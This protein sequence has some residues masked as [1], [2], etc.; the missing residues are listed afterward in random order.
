MAAAS[1][2]T[3]D[4]KLEAC[5]ATVLEFLQSKCLFAAERALRTELELE[6]QRGTPHL[7]ARNLWTSKLENL[8]GCAHAR[9]HTIACTLARLR[10]HAR[11]GS[12]R[13][14]MSVG[15]TF[16]LSAVCM[17][18]TLRWR[19]DCAHGDSGRPSGLGQEAQPDHRILV[20]A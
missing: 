3:T 19:C 13:C 16:G 11:T 10:W 8:L 18:A 12:F 7:L 4:K 2:S 15:I 9:P 20:R 17:P 5:T 14:V 1:T 6:T